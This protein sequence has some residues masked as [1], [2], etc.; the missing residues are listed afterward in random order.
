MVD[1]TH[2]HVAIWIDLYQAV[3]LVFDVV[4]LQR[5]M[6]DRPTGRR[7]QWRVDAGQFLHL[8]HYYKAVLS[9]LE[10]R[11]EILILGPDGAKRELL[12]RI[13]GCKGERGNVVGIHGASRLSGAD[14]V[15]P[16]AEEWPAEDH[17]GRRAVTLTAMP[18][19]ETG[20]TLGRLP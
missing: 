20:G 8:Q 11:D 10:P 3:L 2:R 9:L 18:A 14:L 1:T 19:A 13:K 12:R 15:Y 7:S 4:P 16:T 6:M 5:S 17:D